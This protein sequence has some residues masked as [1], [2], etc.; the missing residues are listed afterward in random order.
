[1]IY[2]YLIKSKKD[3]SYYTGIS[4][5]P[6]KRAIL[7]NRGGLLV[8]KYKRPW[9]LVYKKVHATYAEARKHEKWLKKKNREYKNK[10]AG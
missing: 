8:T 9:V 10:L 2:T 5:D 6:E 1:M 3:G 4:K 7:H